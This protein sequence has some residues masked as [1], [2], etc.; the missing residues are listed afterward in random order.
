MN[1]N[2]MALKQRPFSCIIY[3]C[4]SVC[5]EFCTMLTPSMLCKI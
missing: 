5:W 4:C 2:N 1:F 3:S